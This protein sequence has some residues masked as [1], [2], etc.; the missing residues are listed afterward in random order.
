M[1]WW[2][3]MGVAAGMVW[4]FAI[5][6]AASRLGSYQMILQMMDLGRQMDG[7]DPMWSTYPDE[8]SS[9]RFLLALSLFMVAI[10]P[11]GLLIVVDAVRKMPR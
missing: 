11:F 6:Q 10:G 5:L 8:P 7:A 1:N 3:A 2:L 9:K 4:L